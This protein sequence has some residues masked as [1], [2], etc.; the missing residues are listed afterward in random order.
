VV[1]EI[2][3]LPPRGDP[4]AA[5]VWGPS[6]T[7]ATIARARRPPARHLALAG[8]GL[9]VVAALT[10][11]AVAGA[12]P[13]GET[14]AGN[15]KASPAFSATTTA[16]NPGPS[17]VTPS[18]RDSSPELTPPPPKVA[19][20]AAS[21]AA[22]AALPADPDVAAAE[23]AARPFLVALGRQD[24]DALWATLSSAT[25]RAI[26]GSATDASTSSS[27][28]AGSSGR[29]QLCRGLRDAPPRTLT[30]REPARATGPAQVVIDVESA[31]QI[32]PLALVIEDG[33]WKVNLLGSA[34]AGAPEDP[35]WR[36]VHDLRVALATEQA[37]KAK[38]RRYS[39]DPAELTAR[40]P[41]VH[42]QRGTAPAAGGDGNVFVDGSDTVVCLS[43]RAANGARFMVKMGA[44]AIT[45]ASG[46][47][48][49]GCDSTPLPNPW[50]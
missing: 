47:I 25:I 17:Q 49:S 18:P 16:A 35:V 13:R 34:G 30:V 5:G 20:V 29:D 6:A 21:R 31:G 11:G 36:A 4:A 1:E 43:S 28:D 40:E 50:S 23:R 41:A 38:R 8:A 7:P 22:G 32:E 26:E 44:G 42:W 9:V 2:P 3:V 33:N 48:P 10:V 15:A 14:G 24:C 27:T 39:Y 37:V 19:P 45:Y 46:E 12:W